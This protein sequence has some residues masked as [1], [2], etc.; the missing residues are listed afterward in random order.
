MRTNLMC[1]AIVM[2]LTLGCS[3]KSGF[4]MVMPGSAVTVTERNGST[5]S[6]RLVEVSSDEVVVD[7]PEEG[8]RVLRRDE[9]ASIAVLEDRREATVV[10]RL[11]MSMS[12]E[13]LSIEPALV[14]VR[15]REVT[16]PAG[17]TIDATLETPVGSDVSRVETP[18]VARVVRDLQIDGD[19]IIRLGRNT[20]RQRGQCREAGESQGPRE[21]GIPL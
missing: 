14:R 18:V 19:T 11:A 12:D 1:C 15:M 2:A 3:Q 7:P 8:R 20:E 16:V 10:E 5:V 4:D 9:V 21:R 6:G 17:A 13:G